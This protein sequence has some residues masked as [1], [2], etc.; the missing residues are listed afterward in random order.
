MEAR[1]GFL[2]VRRVRYGVRYMRV[3]VSSQSVTVGW[4]GEESVRTASWGDVH[5][6]RTDC[7]AAEP[8]MA[9]IRSDGG[10]WWSGG[11]RPALG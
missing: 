10:K 11:V 6:I 1:G 8:K 9:V 2:G 3:S 4:G 5:S 7:S